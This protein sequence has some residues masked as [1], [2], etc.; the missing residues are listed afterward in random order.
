MK[1]KK[2][3]NEMNFMFTMHHRYVMYNSVEL[4]ENYGLI[5][6]VNVKQVVIF[7]GGGGKEKIRN[8]ELILI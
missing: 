7:I 1:K 5:L 4:L 2:T 3:I 8:E 6:F